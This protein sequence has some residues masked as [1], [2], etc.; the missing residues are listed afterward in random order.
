MKPILTSFISLVALVAAS[1]IDNVKVN[2]IRAE[3]N[4]LFEP[5]PDVFATSEEELTR[6]RFYAQHAAAAYCNYNAKP[7][8][9]VKCRDCPS[10]ERTKPTVV[11]S[12]T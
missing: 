11:A 12:T 4:A 6:M 9:L 5:S 7:G 3:P 8:S 10:L 2:T 1:P